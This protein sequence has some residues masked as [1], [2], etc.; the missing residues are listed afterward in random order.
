[1]SERGG[2]A[3]RAAKQCAA[4]RQ[5]RAE[6]SEAWRPGARGGTRAPMPGNIVL[7]MFID[8]NDQCTETDQGEHRVQER[9]VEQGKTMNVTP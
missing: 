5:A 2:P 4:R 3:G 9:K 6:P 1:M 7:K 8:Y